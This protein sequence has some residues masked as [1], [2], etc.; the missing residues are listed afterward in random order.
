MSF[1]MNLFKSQIIAR[2]KKDAFSMTFLSFD[3][4]QLLAARA[5]KAAAAGLD[6]PLDFAGAFVARFAGAIVHHQ[7]LLKIAHLAVAVVKIVERRAAGGNGQRQC[8]A[9][10]LH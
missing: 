3:V 9:N 5:V 2:N 10:G 8:F 1:R 7:M 6:D 4:P